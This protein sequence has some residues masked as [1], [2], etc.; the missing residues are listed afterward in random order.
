MFI[1]S[2]R[3]RMQRGVR[4]LELQRTV[5]SREGG[6]DAVPQLQLTRYHAVGRLYRKLKSYVSGRHCPMHVLVWDNQSPCGVRVPSICR[7][8]VL[9][10]ADDLKTQATGGE[11]P[12][13]IATDASS[14]CLQLR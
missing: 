10:S 14:R 6:V 3:S 7:V 4:R 5:K 13:L 1:A 9:N 2:S 8:A 12:L 11:Q